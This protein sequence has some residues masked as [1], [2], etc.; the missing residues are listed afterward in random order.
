MKKKNKKCLFTHR[1]PDPKHLRQARRHYSQSKKAYWKYRVKVISSNNE[2]YNLDPIVSSAPMYRH[3][4]INFFGKYWWERDCTFFPSWIQN[5]VSIIEWER[6]YSGGVRVLPQF[7]PPEDSFCCS[8]IEK[9]QN[10]DAIAE[11]ENWTWRDRVRYWGRIQREVCFPYLEKACNVRINPD[12]SG[13]FLD[14]IDHQRFNCGDEIPAAVRILPE[15]NK[16]GEYARCKAALDHAIVSKIEGVAMYRK[17]LQHHCGGF[18]FY[19]G[20]YR[21]AMGKKHTEIG[22][23]EYFVLLERLLTFAKTRIDTDPELVHI[24]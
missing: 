24:Y 11:E 6:A 16:E 19:D 3:P 4:T 2:K 13:I 5:A 12:G 9:F 7:L 18:C 8:L 22:S 23:D 10:V 20:L 15:Y 17:S 1:K 14:G 21:D